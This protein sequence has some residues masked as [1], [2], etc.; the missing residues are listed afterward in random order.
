MADVSGACLGPLNSLW[1]SWW[2]D[3]KPRL[4][5]VPS[6]CLWPL[7]ALLYLE[8]TFSQ[9]APFSLLISTAWCLMAIPYSAAAMRR[10]AK[11]SNTGVVFLWIWRLEVCWARAGVVFIHQMQMSTFRSASLQVCA[12]CCL[13]TDWSAAFWP[14]IFKAHQNSLWSSRRLCK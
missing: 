8:N 5:P 1:T 4:V 9:R 13:W 12:D 14:N 3:A 6:C 2:P 7:T 10:G 11:L